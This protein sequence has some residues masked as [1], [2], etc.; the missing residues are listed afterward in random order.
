MFDPKYGLFMDGNI[1]EARIAAGTRQG[2]RKSNFIDPAAVGCDNCTLKETW[3]RIRTNRMKMSGARNADILFIGEGPGEQ[4]DAE[5]KAFVGP[6]GKLLREYIPSRH[7]DRVAFQNAVRCRP[8]GNRTPTVREV[9]ACSVHLN[10]DI[11]SLPLRAIVGVGSVPLHKYFPGGQIMKLH[12]TRFPV[13]TNRGPIWY[14]PILHPAFVLRLAQEQERDESP[15]LPVFQS[16]M[17][18]FFQYVDRWEAP[19]V[20]DIKE[21]DVIL[22]R[23]ADEARALIATM[24]EPV[25]VDVETHPLHPYQMD[26]KL[27][28]AGIS[29]G[30]MTIAFPCEHPEG[31]TDWGLDVLLETLLMKRWIAHNASFEL[32]WFNWYWNDYIN[33]IQPFDDSMALGRLYHQSKNILSLEDL[34]VV[35][36]GINI[37]Q[38]VP[39][40]ASRIMAFPLSQVLPYNGLDALGSALLW[41]KL[42]NE[43]EIRQDSY[44]RILGA[45]VA[46]NDMELAGLP[47]DLAESARLET[48]WKARYDQIISESLNLEEVRRFEQER[49][50]NFNL[51]SNDH[52]GVALTAYGGIN[53]QRTESKVKVAW[54]TDEEALKPYVETNALAKA[55]LE[56]REAAKMLSTYIRP[57]L[58]APKRYVDGR[59]HGNYTTMHT[60]PFRLSSTDPNMQN[61]PWRKHGEVRRQ[62]IAEPG[63]V[64]VKFDFG[65][66][67]IRVEGMET[68]DPHLIDILIKGADMH[69]EWRDR[70]LGYYPDYWQRMMEKTGEMEEAKI[71]KGG[72][73]LIKSDFVFANMFGATVRSV[74]ERTGIPQSI[75]QRIMRE[76][77][78]EFKDILAWI[79][80]RRAE[81]RDTGMVTSMTGHV[82][83][84]LLWGNEP[85]NAP[86]QFGEATIVMDAMNELSALARREKNFHFA[87]RI[88]IHDDLTFMLPND[89]DLS[90]YIDVIQRIMVRKRFPWQVVPLNVEASIGA[91]WGQFE[92]IATF[93]G[94][95]VR[96]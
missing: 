76:F 40:D 11:D 63:C 53:L 47:V 45:I 85:I 39:V 26:A 89:N 43:R 93:T 91:N 24:Q 75:V 83:R 48:T 42:H 54:V 57:L 37:K 80:A 86:I 67:Q 65:Q 38:I 94:D 30:N 3:T 58:E 23:T 73:D 18:R 9:H 4:E 13:M 36:L 14:Y 49:A 66:L 56:E 95:Y 69:S 68:R 79:K 22:P 71:L 7:N 78:T 74:A 88:Q 27:L 21:S 62:I 87:P 61:F 15:A 31:P 34:S 2:T 44:N 96:V 32:G 82:R 90:K 5:G 33:D 50:I 19:H 8:D 84:G 55:V 17:R 81:Y 16:D 46:T 6:S 72:R 59:L 29:D 12:G 51:Q 25:G 64:M 35:H 77:W 70:I 10:A 20:C 41:Q 52:V 92:Q 28:T 60:H 1:A